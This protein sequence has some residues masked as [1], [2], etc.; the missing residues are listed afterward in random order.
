MQSRA[1]PRLLCV[2]DEPNVLDALA[3]QLRQRWDVVTATGGQSGLERLVRDGPF[4]VVM[5]DMR[6]PGMNGA[7]FLATART[8]AK[9]TVR[10]LLTGQTEI[11]AA[12]A[13]VN[14]GHIFRFL[15]K[16]CSGETLHAYANA[17]IV[18][19]EGQARLPVRHVSRYGKL[20][21]TDLL[22]TEEVAHRFD[23]LK[24]IVEVGLEV[25]FH[26]DLPLLFRF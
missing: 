23:G 22:P 24:L 25:Q 9:D 14:E 7:A 2:D 10:L 21:A 17:E 18:L 3:R 26:F 1:K 20:C 12:I 11:A 13:A 6:M 4:A 16:P 19:R 8:V 15:T 5:S